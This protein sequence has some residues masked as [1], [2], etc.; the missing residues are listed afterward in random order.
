MGGYAKRKFD[1]FAGKR[2]EHGKG[3]GKERESLEDVVKRGVE[4]DDAKFEK[5]LS[6]KEKLKVGFRVVDVATSF[7]PS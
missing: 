2:M 6:R 7:R 4:V 1:D 5:P 3:K